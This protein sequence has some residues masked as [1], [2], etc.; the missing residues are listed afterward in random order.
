MSN[1]TI[2]R[3]KFI[4][5]QLCAGLI[6]ASLLIVIMLVTGFGQDIP[7]TCGLTR[8]QL[9]KMIVECEDNG[10]LPEG[11]CTVDINVRVAE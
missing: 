4:V 6:G 1:V 3:G 9:A 2:P 5:K 10:K 7:G 11:T 8:L